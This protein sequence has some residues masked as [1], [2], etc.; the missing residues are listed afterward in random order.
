VVA[1]ALLRLVE[2]LVVQEPQTKDMREE[3]HLLALRL[4]VEVVEPVV[5]ELQIA[6]VLE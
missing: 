3:M 5:R 6:E 4:V 1:V 2:Q